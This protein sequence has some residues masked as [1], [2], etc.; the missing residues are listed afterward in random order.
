MCVDAQGRLEWTRTYG[1]RKGERSWALTDMPDGGYVVAGQTRSWGAGDWDAYV[2]RVDSAGHQMWSRVFGGPGIDRAL[3]V[4]RTPSGDLAVTGFTTATPESDRDAFVALLSPDGRVKWNR[5]IHG[6]RAE[7][8]HGVT[9]DGGGTI[10]VTGYGNSWGNGDNDVDLW[11]VGMDGEVAAR[12]ELGSAEVDDRAMMTA[13]APDATLL[14]IGYI[15]RRAGDWDVAIWRTSPDGHDP[16]RL[17]LSNPGDDRG[18]FAL[19]ESSRSLVL[20][21]AWAAGA[22][23]PPDVILSRLILP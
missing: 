20:T 21:G 3:N 23:R 11:S 2:L 16:V 18:V 14:V 8:G 17:V 9:L 10:L 12:R 22:G 5:T 1:G 13:V 15:H 6:E 7:V 19:A 4:A